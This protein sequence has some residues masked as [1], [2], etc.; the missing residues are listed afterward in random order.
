MTKI[1]VWVDR[2][3]WSIIVGLLSIGAMWASNASALGQK[4][5]KSAVDALAASTIQS[6]NVMKDDI[7]TLKYLACKSNPND[8]VCKPR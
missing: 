7:A 1:D 4:A 2:H 3:G 8:S 5:E 6:V